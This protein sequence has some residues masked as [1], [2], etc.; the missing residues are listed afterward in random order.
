MLFKAT[1]VLPNRC[2]RTCINHKNES[3]HLKRIKKT[4]DDSIHYLGGIEVN[5]TVSNT[6]LEILSYAHPLENKIAALMRNQI[7]WDAPGS[8]HRIQPD[9]LEGVFDCAKSEV[10]AGFQTLK[11][12]TIIALWTGLEIMIEDLFV[13]WM[14]D[15]PSCLHDKK[16]QNIKIPLA[17]FCTLET[18][19]LIRKLYESYI[20]DSSKPIGIG[21]F[22][23]VL[24]AL[25][26]KEVENAPE[27]SKSIYELNLLRNLFAH[28]GGRVDVK[29]HQTEIGQAYKL[30]DIFYLYDNQFRGYCSHAI[31]YVESILSRIENTE[32]DGVL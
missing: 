22:E 4:L 6:A 7:N 1:E 27:I 13:A 19:P 32:Q 26:V 12:Q 5:Y 25:G 24:K 20:K 30:G 14:F 29:F 16:F 8:V 11:A 17:E 15:F 2:C 21:R 31:Q 9:E 18:E 3:K 28:Q 10:H 23:L